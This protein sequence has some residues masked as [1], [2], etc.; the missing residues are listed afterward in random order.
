MNAGQ[1]GSQT[2]RLRGADGIVDSVFTSGFLGDLMQPQPPCSV[3]ECC[4]LNDDTALEVCSPLFH[5]SVVINLP[6]VDNS[7][8]HAIRETCSLVQLQQ[9]LHPDLYPKTMPLLC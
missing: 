8:C 9:L 3:A 5:Q 6:V 2:V 1:G 7:V 4:E